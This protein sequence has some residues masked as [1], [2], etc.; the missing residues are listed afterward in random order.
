MTNKIEKILK[1][2][3][4]DLGKDLIERLIPGSGESNT[5]QGELIRCLANITGESWG[6]MNNNWIYNKYDYNEQ[7][8]PEGYFPEFWY[9]SDE[10]IPD[11][12]KCNATQEEIDNATYH[13]E[14]LN[15]IKNILKN[16]PL[17]EWSEEH[18]L[19]IQQILERARPKVPPGAC[20]DVMW[21]GHESWSSDDEDFA[22]SKILYWIYS[23]PQLKDL[24]GNILDENI[25]DIFNQYLPESINPNKT[26]DTGDL[27][28]KKGEYYIAPNEIS[29]INNLE[30]NSEE[31]YRLS[32]HENNDV[33]FS[34]L[35]KL[36]IK[37]SVLNQAI[38]LLLSK[39][40]N[41]KA[42]KILVNDDCNF[43][44]LLFLS[45][46]DKLERC[47]IA[48]SLHLPNKLYSDLAMDKSWEG[49]F[50]F[51]TWVRGKVASNSE[52]SSEL[53]EKLAN[54]DD[55]YVRREAAENLKAPVKLLK[56]LAKDKEPEVHRGVAENSNTPSDL[57][58]KLS[59]DKYLYVRSSVAS[60]SK[61]PEETLTKLTC[62]EDEFLLHELSKNPN[63]SEDIL[64]KL[65]K[66]EDDDKYILMGISENPK[67]PISL[68][69]QL[70]KDDELIQS[71]A[72]NTAL[73]IKFLEKLSHSNDVWVRANVAKNK[74]TPIA[75]LEVLTGDKDKSVREGVADNINCPEKILDKLSTDKSEEV[76]NSVSSNK[77]TSPDTLIRLS[78]DRKYSVWI[79]ALNNSNCP[80]L[81]FTDED[82][83]LFMAGY[84]FLPEDIIKKYA[85]DN[86]IEIRSK[87]ANNPLIPSLVQLELC[88]DKIKVRRA[89]A[90]STLL[91]SSTAE[92]LASD[93]DVGV[94][95][96][97]AKSKQLD[98][99]IKFK[100]L[101][102]NSI[103][104]KRN[105]VIYNTLSELLQ[106]KIMM[107]NDI[108]L[109]PSLLKNKNIMPELR[110]KIESSL[111]P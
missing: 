12:S 106:K 7:S 102:D 78:D 27:L 89:L 54:D 33:R 98:E 32:K 91:Y 76:R 31:I 83:D 34:V 107:D 84:P 73:P 97:L 80:P 109:I 29:D 88:N 67:T 87:L 8:Y 16:H 4:F 56:K 17:P 72:K 25:I 20:N 23:N 30:T 6:N 94:R 50:E 26:S 96:V 66:K 11:I 43:L 14:Q 79:A 75:V 103:Q 41:K 74:S 35:K 95:K 24:K 64:I 59:N 28:S 111:T 47:T 70:I 82:I 51:G 49:E 18:Q 92:K 71:V 110:K 60:N 69:E 40:S 22:T 46:F 5:L 77:N 81:N 101:N 58:N 19:L 108:E 3:E 10:F 37:S 21:S 57:L 39:H 86:N 45:E 68:L 48:E 2:N 9:E 100:L 65:S 62:E 90:K 93:D 63:L 13:D 99:K 44:R 105:L 55:W 53:L 36:K 38:K 15:L 42:S 1:E 85:K 61:T 52:I 104:V